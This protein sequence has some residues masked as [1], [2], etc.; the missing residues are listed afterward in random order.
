MTPEEF[1]GGSYRSG[2]TSSNYQ[3][4]LVRAVLMEPS[5]SGV[6]VFVPNEVTFPITPGLGHYLVANESAVESLTVR[7]YLDS[8]DIYVIPPLSHVVLSFTNSSIDALK[9]IA[10]SRHDGLLDFSADLPDDAD[11]MEIVIRQNMANFN[12]M[13]AAIGLGW[14]QVSPLALTVIVEPTVVVHSI[15]NGQP[16]MTTGDGWPSGSRFTLMNKGTVI[17]IG[18]RG[19]RGGTAQ[20]PSVSGGFPGEA[21]GTALDIYLQSVIVNSGL[22]AGGGGGGGGGDA[23]GTLAAPHGGGGGGGCP[24]GAGGN[25]SPG[26]QQ[27]SGSP[28]FFINGRIPTSSVNLSIA[29]GGGANANG[30]TVLGSGG[31]GGAPGTAGTAGR[32]TTGTASASGLG[33]AA[34]GW[35]RRP[36]AVTRIYIAQGAGATAGIEDIY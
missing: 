2:P 28:L 23:P 25:A 31:G 19:G 34:G 24:G 33:G 13:T 36:L 3:L 20:L 7:N 12:A 27:G 29:G 26:A 11:S 9:W 15:I 30:S 5:T 8:T 32:T 21:G 6:K 22:M 17:G 16:A 4:N 35:I 10:T 18:G 1:Y 14:D